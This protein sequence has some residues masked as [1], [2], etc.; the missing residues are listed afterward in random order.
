MQL[1]MSIDR[2]GC[3]KG[4][5]RI[6]P[7]L[8]AL[9]SPCAGVYVLMHVWGIRIQACDDRQH[10]PRTRCFLCPC[11]ARLSEAQ[12]SHAAALQQLEASHA[13]ALRKAEAAHA[14][15]MAKCQAEAE[16]QLGS[17]TQQMEQLKRDVQAQLAERGEAQAKT[18]QELEDR[19]GGSVWAA[20]G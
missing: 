15:A 12:R 5:L 2:T 18:L 9:A 14:A 11:Q 17:L 4:E 16:A 7:L 6:K 10:R 3:S 13:K 20:G 8:K 1:R 19:C